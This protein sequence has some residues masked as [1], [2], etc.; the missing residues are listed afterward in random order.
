MKNDLHVYRKAVS[1]P[2]FWA[3]LAFLICLWIM[4]ILF[5]T[6]LYAVDRLIFF[7]FTSCGSFCW[8]LMKTPL[9]S[10]A[11]FVCL[12]V[13]YREVFW[14][15]FS[16]LTWRELSIQR[17]LLFWVHVMFLLSLPS[18]VGCSFQGQLL[19]IFKL[20]RL[21]FARYYLSSLTAPENH[22]FSVICT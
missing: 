9:L 4:T 1:K 7:P 22:V 21:V 3:I 20:L 14:E 16:R 18:R 5:L 13:G 15:E 11:G 19:S 2:N 12:R 10:S 17:P 6:Y 8:G